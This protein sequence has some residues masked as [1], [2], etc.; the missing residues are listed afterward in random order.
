M[1][2][3]LAT[4]SLV[5]RHGRKCPDATEVRSMSLSPGRR[6]AE[7]FADLLDRAART[8]DP[9]LAP[10]VALAG[11]LGGVAAPD[12]PRPE[13]R[14]A[15]RQRLVA[16]GTVQGIG[17]QSASP[18]AR[19]RELGGSWRFQRRVAVV[20]GGAA[21]VTA[22]AGVGLS[23]SRSLPGDAFYGLKRATESVQLAA[24]HG[25]E[26]KGKKHLEFARTRLSEVKALTER[27]VA[28]P[29]VV[30]GHP[31]AAGSAPQNADTSTIVATLRDMDD[32]TRAG[33][34]ALMNVYRASGTIEPLRALD[35]FTHE[36]YADLLALLPKLPAA[37]QPRARR[38]LSLLRIVNVQTVALA[39]PSKHG[40]GSTTP[41]PTATS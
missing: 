16:V 35:S 14:T 29:A 23:A 11:A 28:L 38:S 18:A 4:P 10:L 21:A 34:T 33:A 36:Q 25:Q 31:T 1:A 40:S 32:E 2:R 24:T 26:A 19:V 27:G 3:H 8:D 17:E 5:G 20:A 30:P 41:T 15:L 37:A 22:V 13:F 9:T 7:R 12:G 6:H 39:P